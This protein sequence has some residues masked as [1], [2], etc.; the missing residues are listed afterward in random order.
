VSLKVEAWTC[1]TWGWTWA[2][3]FFCNPPISTVFPLCQDEHCW[4]SFAHQLTFFFLPSFWF[5]HPLAHRLELLSYD[6]L[7][8]RPS[9]S[10]FPSKLA[11]NWVSDLSY[12]CQFK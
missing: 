1:L 3:Q 7:G 6:V 4:Q 10:L 5:V 12:G 8:Y 9:T 11:M 2:F